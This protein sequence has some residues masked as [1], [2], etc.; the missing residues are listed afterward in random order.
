MIVVVRHGRLFQASP[1]TL[2]V[3]RPAGPLLVHNRDASSVAAGAHPRAVGVGGRVVACSRRRVAVVVMVVCLPH[4]YILLVV[5]V[6]LGRLGSEAHVAGGDVGAAC[7]CCVGGHLLV[8]IWV[9]L[10]S[11]VSRIVTGGYMYW[12]LFPRPRLS[13]LSI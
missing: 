4:G 12:E 2:D 8:V 11:R 10:L 7:G 13:G 6:L 5:I 9:S 1:S 3:S